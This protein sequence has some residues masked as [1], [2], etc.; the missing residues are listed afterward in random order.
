MVHPT[1]RTRTPYLF[2]FDGQT[3]ALGEPSYLY[4]INEYLLAAGA[5]TRPT[6]WD[7]AYLHNIAEHNPEDITWQLPNLKDAGGPTSRN[8]LN[9]IGT[10][11]TEEEFWAAIEKGIFNTVS[12]SGGNEPLYFPQTPEWLEHARAWEFDPVA[13]A[14]GPG[15]LGGWTSTRTR[16]GQ[17][18]PVGLFQLTSND[19]FWAFGS[20]EDLEALYELC[21]DLATYRTGFNQT[22]IYYG[23]DGNYSSLAF[24]LECRTTLEEELFIAGV[25]T[26]TLFWD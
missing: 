19:S 4:T 17:G 6:F 15:T 3:V 24:P 9:S 26:E 25:D 10:N 18:Y 7:H 8:L 14:E 20:A 5:S 16:A 11:L 21:T 13:P 1:H 12:W 22:T 2:H 23:Q